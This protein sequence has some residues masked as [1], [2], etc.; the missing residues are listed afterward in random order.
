M[1]LCSTIKA[2]SSNKSERAN[3]AGFLH[4]IEDTQ[5]EIL[6]TVSE[7]IVSRADTGTQIKVP[8]IEESEKYIDA[9][10]DA[11]NFKLNF[12]FNLDQRVMELFKSEKDN[13]SSLYRNEDMGLYSATFL[14]QNKLNSGLDSV[15]KKK[16]Q[17]LQLEKK[18][19]CAKI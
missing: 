4:Q 6:K 17:L 15:K 3:I 10:A 1:A 16:Y 13:L 11:D 5:V 2:Q 12:N 18:Y 9:A 8:T 7:K 19:W 14:S